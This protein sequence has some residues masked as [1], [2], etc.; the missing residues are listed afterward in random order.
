M[1]FVD[2]IMC[3]TFNKRFNNYKLTISKESLQANNFIKQTTQL[4]K[5]V[6]NAASAQSR[7]KASGC[8]PVEAKACIIYQLELKQNIVHQLEPSRAT[9][10]LFFFAIVWQPVLFHH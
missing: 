9:H 5:I 8:P 7:S 10:I 2:A 3:L 1:H 4:M 6:P